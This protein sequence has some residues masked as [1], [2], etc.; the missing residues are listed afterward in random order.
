[1]PSLVGIL[2]WFVLVNYVTAKLNS[3]S[4]QTI[5][6]FLESAAKTNV[7]WKCADSL[8]KIK[9]FLS[10][11]DTIE[12]QKKFLTSSYS[13]G[14]TY[15]VEGRDQ[16]RWIYKMQQCHAV[17]GEKTYAHSEHPT[18]YCIGR[19]SNSEPSRTYGIC[20][21]QPCHEDRHKLLEEW[22]DSVG[23]SSHP[24]EVHSVECRRS[25]REKHWL[26]MWPSILDYSITF[27]F[28][29]IVGLATAYDITRGGTMAECG[30]SS[31]AKKVFLAYSLKKNGKKLIALPKDTHTTM[32]CMFGIRFFSMAWVIGGHSFVMA[33]AFLGN[34]TIYENHG[35]NFENQWMS[36]GTVCVDTFFLLS[37]IL[38]SFIF[39]RGYGFKER[40]ITWRSYRFW[41]MFVL[42]R[43]LRLW[44]A[45]IMAISNLSFRWSFTLTQEPWPYH[46]SFAQ[47]CKDWWKN[48]LF[49]N[50]IT[51]SWCMPWTWYISADF[52]FNLFAPIYLLAL[53][54]SALFGLSLCVATILASSLLNIYTMIARNFPPVFLFFRE[55]PS[56]FVDNFLE[57]LES[58]YIQPQYRIGPYMVGLLVGYYLAR[59]S[60][61][62]SKY[63]PSK[64]MFTAGSV[65]AVVAGFCSL[66]GSYP[67]MQGWDWPVFYLIYGC[68]YR[69]VWSICVAWLI[70]YC[71]VHQ[72][73][74]INRFLSARFFI[75]LSNLCYSVSHFHIMLPLR[76]YSINSRLYKDVLYSQTPDTSKWSLKMERG[77]VTLYSIYSF[78]Q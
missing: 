72:S 4:E 66:Y 9:P 53:K 62:L 43:A 40:G 70:Y 38:T 78:E 5:F 47:C 74:L 23:N 6:G 19:D 71:Y 67:L 33:Q 41:T 14:M 8:K 34:V 52:I 2:L 29:L 63:C 37:A 77:L 28:I 1:M 11:Y 64:S 12:D 39:F 27:T 42:H 30:E 26:E 73:S 56:Q 68:S 50:S 7:S 31:T 25:R 24:I 21:P 15:A 60:M 17:A 48:L 59:I 54:R 69:T 76:P 49:I 10:N 20:L 16:F 61:G 35:S 3:F 32:T 58:T 65:C 75:P 22:K 51:Y 36:N 44:P 45:Y 18:E 57:Q 46:D 55:P 13:V